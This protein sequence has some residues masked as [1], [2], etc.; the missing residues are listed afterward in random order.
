MKSKTYKLHHIYIMILIFLVSIFGIENKMLIGET[1]EISMNYRLQGK[2]HGKNKQTLV[3]RQIDYYSDLGYTHMLYPF[4]PVDNKHFTYDTFNNRW[5]Y[6]AKYSAD[7]NSGMGGTIREIENSLRGHNLVLIPEIKTLSQVPE[8]ITFYP[9]LSVVPVY[10][11]LKFLRTSFNDRMRNVG[12]VITNKN[13]LKTR[14]YLTVDRKKYNANRPLHIKGFSRVETGIYKNSVSKILLKIKNIKNTES[15]VQCDLYRSKKAYNNMEPCTIWINP[16]RR[17]QFI[18][19]GLILISQDQFDPILNQGNDQLSE[20]KFSIGVINSK[21]SIN[22]AI[23]LFR[24]DGGLAF[25]EYDHFH[26]AKEPLSDITGIISFIAYTEYCQQILKAPINKEQKEYPCRYNHIVKPLTGE[27]VFEDI[28]ICANLINSAFEENLKIL[29]ASYNNHHTIWPVEQINWD[30]VSNERWPKTISINYNSLSHYGIGLIGNNHSKYTASGIAEEI[31]Y[32]IHQIDSW[33]PKSK[34]SINIILRGESFLPPS[35]QRIR[36]Q[37]SQTQSLEIIPEFAKLVDDYGNPIGNRIIIMVNTNDFSNKEKNIVISYMSKYSMNYII[38]FPE[39]KSI[40]NDQKRQQYVVDAFNW[41]VAEKA[42][43]SF[44][45][46]YAHLLSHPWNT[47]FTNG[48]K[49][50]YNWKIPYGIYASFIPHMATF[51]ELTRPY[52]SNSRYRLFYTPDLVSGLNWVGSRKEMRYTKGKHWQIGLNPVCI[53]NKGVFSVGNSGVAL[54]GRWNKTLDTY[55]LS[56]TSGE[57][58]GSHNNVLFAYIPSVG[59]FYMEVKVHS[60]GSYKAG[61]MVRENLSP[62]SKLVHLFFTK[63]ILHSKT[64]VVSKKETGGSTYDDGFTINGGNYLRVS[65]TKN[66]IE[67]WAGRDNNSYRLLYTSDFIKDSVY[68]G[69]THVLG[70]NRGNQFKEFIFDQR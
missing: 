70:T 56:G 17:S 25:N 42:S 47:T 66:K 45:Y 31:K 62:S 59:D 23:D 10:A 9:E 43:N 65:R 7:Y 54:F 32:R 26:F 61:I 28:N 49:I 16:G 33:F 41:F 22:Y 12:I 69:L 4:S 35:V 13:K 58:W 51:S 11:N 64:G 60:Q 55:T 39:D 53:T 30:T 15:S 34:G 6:G 19:P 24:Q 27:N 2:L 37:K 36:Y 46:G 44:C 63:N 48:S 5:W 68:V 52:S 50:Y 18:V 38:G 67:F 21:D 14:Y 3:S 29:R 57:L 20:T 1:H 8:M 40:A